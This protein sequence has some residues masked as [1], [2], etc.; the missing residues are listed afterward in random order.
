MVS[1]YVR[2]KNDV[3]SWRFRKV[4]EGRGI[5]TGDLQPP[6]YIR[7]FV[8]GKQAWKA[9]L[10]TSFTG[11]R[12]EAGRTADAL[13]AHSKGLTVAEADALANAN[14]M[15]IKTAGFLTMSDVA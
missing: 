15:T 6:F 7:P 9:L 11:A 3:G 1:V 12:E 5:K 8:N 13:E 2:E 4:R 10:A 14:R